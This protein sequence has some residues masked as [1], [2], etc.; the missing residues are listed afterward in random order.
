MLPHYS[1]DSAP[2]DLFIYLYLSMV[3]DLEDDEMAS[4]EAYEVKF[5]KY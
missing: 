4:R 2:S 3:N 1:V 5:S